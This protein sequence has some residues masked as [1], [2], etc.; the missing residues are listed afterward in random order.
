V[1]ILFALLWV[2]NFAWLTPAF[3][4]RAADALTSS[5]SQREQAR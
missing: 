5:F 4:R 1:I 3:C 2:Y